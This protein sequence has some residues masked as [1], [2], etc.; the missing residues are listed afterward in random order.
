MLGGA[1]PADVE[2]T[3]PDGGSG[4]FGQPSAPLLMDLEARF[5]SSPGAS[6]GAWLDASGL[7][8]SAAGCE[9][10]RLLPVAEEL[11]AAAADSTALAAGRTVA[12][13]GI[14]SIATLL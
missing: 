5:R 6:V 14:G 7:R 8:G 11:R 3:L 13:R 10:V 4:F 12:T 9:G 1:P 2:P